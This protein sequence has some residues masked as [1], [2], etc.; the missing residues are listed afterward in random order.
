MLIVRFVMYRRLALSILVALLLSLTAAPVAVS[1]QGLHPSY[2]PHGDIDT[3]PFYPDGTYDPSV[4]HPDHYLQQDIGQWPLRYHELVEYL[5]ALDGSTDRVIIDTEGETYEGRAIYNVFISTP[6]N[7]EKIE[8]VRLAV[9]QLANAEQLSTAALDSIAQ[10]VPAIAWMGYSIHG[11]ELSG[12]DAATRLIYQLAAGTD[13]LTQ[14]LLENLVII[15]QPSQNPDGRERY[16]SMLQTYRSTVPNW[17]R[18]A[19]QHSGV[20]PWGRTNHYLFDLNRDW[21]LLRQQ[22]TRN[23][24]ATLIRWNPQLVVDG[25]EMGS[26]ATFLFSPPRQP[27]NYH[28]P[29]HY[30]D[31]ADKFADDQAKAFDDRSWP[32][33]TGE[34]HE[35]WYPGYG[36]AWPTYFG[37]VGV[38]YEMAGV[39]GQVVRQ[40]DDY[41]LTYHE[42]VNKQFTSSLA[43]L[44]TL[45]NNREIFLRQYYQTRRSIID[46]GRREGPTYLF[47]PDNDELKMKR[48]IESLTAQAIEVTRATEGFTVSNVI[49]RYSD[50]RGSMSFPAGTYIVSAAQP[51]GALVQ[52]ILEFDP[53]LKLEFLK[54]ERRELEKFG[55]TRMYE[56]SAWSPALAYDLDAYYTNGIVSVDDEPVA[57]VPLSVGVLQNAN[58]RYGFI[59]PMV[60]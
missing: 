36:S 46:E 1:A 14:H 37:A 20:W 23:K 49:D 31:W 25:H 7:I 27:I 57:E 15:V 18:Y 34:W 60:G 53:K 38:L 47:K 50:E 12:T 40:R 32:Y 45:A 19:M 56:V 10:N 5:A 28:T 44:Q 54:E 2:S 4:P 48:F 9:Q 58:A 24:I 55:D 52:A 13:S 43:N 35:H 41:L 42:A 17:D 39:D 11:D 29:Q 30:L 6:S 22:E 26:N 3:V 16:L 8:Q 21:I 33:Y 51:H 59:V